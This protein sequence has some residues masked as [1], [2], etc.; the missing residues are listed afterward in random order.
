MSQLKVSSKWIVSSF[1][2]MLFQNKF[3]IQLPIPETTKP[4]SYS[5]FFN[6]EFSLSWILSFCTSFSSHLWNTFIL[7]LIYST[8]PKGSCAKLIPHS[9]LQ[10]GQLL[11][12][13]NIFY[14]IFDKYLIFNLS[15]SKTSLHC[16]FKIFT[17]GLARVL[18]C[19]NEGQP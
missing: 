17:S 8:A 9:E 13:V 6:L 7:Y 10:R 11:D 1:I 12:A 2:M 14:L 4:K 16:S 19:N 15:I 3:P 18:G 5:V